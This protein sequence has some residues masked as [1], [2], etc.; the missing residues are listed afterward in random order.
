MDKMGRREEI[1]G[2]EERG[3]GHIEPDAQR[4]G[5]GRT[6]DPRVRFFK[7][8]ELKIRIDTSNDNK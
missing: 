3:Q 1:R 4:N 5:Y 7:F 8:G 2:G 6:N